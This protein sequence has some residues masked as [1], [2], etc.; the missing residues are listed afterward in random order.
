MQYY[1][2][3]LIISYL[4]SFPFLIFAQDI[5]VDLL[6]AVKRNELN[7]VKRLVEQGAEVNFQDENKASVL[8]WAVYKADIQVVKYLIDKKADF[9]QKTGIIWLNDQ[10]TAYY[11]NLTGIAA[12]ENK[13]ETLKYLLETCKISVDD[14]E[15]NPEDQQS[16][17]WTALQ[18]AASKGHTQVLDYLILKQANLHIFDGNTPLTYALINKHSETAKLLIRQGADLSRKNKEGYTPLHLASFYDLPEV[19]RLLIAQ[20]VD[21]NVP[22]DTNRPQT[23]FELAVLQGL[24]EVATVFIEQGIDVNQKFGTGTTAL[25]EACKNGYYDL[26]KLL[27][28]QKADV[29]TLA[30]GNLSPLMYAA[31]NNQ[32]RICKLL[33]DNGAKLDYQTPEGKTALDFAVE[34][35][36]VETIAFLQNPN[37]YQEPEYW[38]LL[39]Q[40]A[41]RYYNQKRPEKALEFL[42]KARA[43]VQEKYG[44]KSDEYASA[45]LNLADF[46]NATQQLSNAEKNILQS[47]NIRKSLKSKQLIKSLESLGNVYYQQGKYQDAQKIYEQVLDY[48]KQ[49]GGEKSPAY[50][51]HLD[52]LGN[53]HYLLGNYNSSEK[54]FKQAIQLKKANSAVHTFD[55]A[56]SLSNLG[57]LWQDMGKYSEAK[58]VYKESLSIFAKNQAA[59]DYRWE[60]HLTVLGNYTDLFYKTGEYSI[61][62]YRYKYT[63]LGSIPEG[64]EYSNKATILHNLGALYLD[65]GRLEEAETRLKEALALKLKNLHENHPSYLNTYG[66]LADLYTQKKQFLQAEKMY[67]YILNS[68]KTRFGEQYPAYLIALNNLAALY[69]AMQKDAEAEKNYLK[70]L[71]IAQKTTENLEPQYATYLN[72]LGNFYF[73]NARYAEAEKLLLRAFAIRQKSLHPKHPDYGVSLRNL[74]FLY[75]NWN[76]LD[77]AEPHFLA[78]NQNFLQQI[79]NFLPFMSEKAQN[80][81]VRTF[82]EYFE[83]FTAFAIQYSNTKPLIMSDLCNIRLTTKALL[84]NFKNLVHKN[85]QNQTD[86]LARKYYQNWIA[87]KEFLNK[88]YNLSQSE[89]EKQ[90]LSIAN[91]EKI[92]NNTE[93]ILNRLAIKTE[94]D[95]AQLFTWQTVQKLLK[96][97]EYAIE[98]IRFKKLIPKQ[99]SVIQ[100][101]FLIIKANQSQPE[102][103]VLENGKDLETKHLKYFQNSIKFKKEDKNSYTHYWQGLALVLAKS[104]GLKRVY[105]SPDGV[106]NQ[107]SINALRNSIS[108]KYLLDELD[109]VLLTNLKEIAQTPAKSID[110]LK[111]AIFFG[112]P[113]YNIDEPQHKNAVRKLG[114]GEN[115]ELEKISPSP[116]QTSDSREMQ[117]LTLASLPGTKVEIDAI[118]ELARK[119]GFQTQKYLQES[120]LE[121]LVKKI[122]QP[123]VLHIATH[124]YFL[125]DLDEQAANERIL[126]IQRKRLDINPLLR[127]GLMLTGAERSLRS[128][129]MDTQIENGI[130]T[131]YEAMSLDLTNTELVVLSA[132]ET[133]LGEVKTG[134]GVYGLQRAFKVAGAQS[135]LMS[136]WT[137]SDEATSEL[138][139]L[140]YENWFKTNQRREAFRQAQLKLREKY[141]EPYYWGAFVLVGE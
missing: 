79:K 94:A 57:N 14:Q 101:A 50:L 107:L 131:A 35:K 114:R 75:F 128:E 125:K 54:L 28:D 33:L 36:M 21:F 88:L 59:K 90:G 126:G 137:V 93:S 106:Y 13:L 129:L 46:Q 22:T 7:E 92:V 138:M 6:I 110:S 27:I 140:F 81:F 12:A 29:N 25:H 58:E 61:A 4:N 118:E 139:Q 111:T 109:L 82:D 124:G 60:R 87:E 67:L 19:V 30:K 69:Q 76:K 2:K 135:I 41:V 48:H 51:S 105:F 89:L 45:L 15:Y 32:T 134:E 117:Q 37:G 85:L 104:E 86:T 17:G 112:Y 119:N 77:Q 11:G 56:I 38:H 53:L 91:Q 23:A 115:I 83:M 102:I 103:L 136:M 84:L 121:E 71:Q 55:Y 43:Y 123:K 10:K 122:K 8:M 5:N 3:L 42:E 16:K 96:A 74:A 31:Y 44:E 100:Y 108:G 40:E 80:E 39:N 26:A 1:F 132:C 68:Y 78:A 20:K 97:N 130:L 127:S 116:S 95:F 113:I 47:V 62:E 18:W 133:G 34:R 49:N 24:L 72:N 9:T 141:P 52:I 73:I 64:K 65:M 70:V 120:A 66:T 99:A 63:I 98:T